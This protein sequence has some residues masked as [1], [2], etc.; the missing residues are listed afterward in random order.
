MGAEVGTFLSVKGVRFGYPAGPEF[1]GPIDL[2]LGRGECWAIVGP[3]GAGKSTLL[4]LLAGLLRPRRGT[5]ELEGAA[6]AALSARERAR[7]VA[8]IPQQV[9]SDIEDTARGLVL[10]GRFPHRSFGLFETAHDLAVAERALALTETLDFA[11]RP[12]C[13]LSGGEAQRVHVAAALAQEPR[14]LLADEPTASLDVQHQ[15]TI[16]RI[17]RGQAVR[18]GVTVVVVTHDVNLAAQFC[19]HVLVL[20]NGRIVAC[21]PPAEVVRAQVLSPIYNTPLVEACAPEAPAVCWVVPHVLAGEQVGD[22]SPR[23]GPLTPPPPPMG[24]RG[25]ETAPES[26]RRPSVHQSPRSKDLGHPRDD[27]GHPRDDLGHP[28]GGGRG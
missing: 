13:T 20:D 27:L 12:L 15:L 18:E 7:R 17:L 16:F 19:T 6:L 5:I 24:E 10:L 3:N 9:R 14:L 26:V 25:L 4:R 1:L 2:R 8:L 21:G 11:E 22:Q 23:C 28:K